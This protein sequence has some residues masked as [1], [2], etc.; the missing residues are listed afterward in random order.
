MERAEERK[1]PEAIDPNNQPAP[2]NPVVLVREGREI[3]FNRLYKK[4]VT[5]EAT[6]LGYLDE[7]GKLQPAR[8]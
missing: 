4:F 1:D 3:R 5:E 7:D 6:L 2:D 8:K